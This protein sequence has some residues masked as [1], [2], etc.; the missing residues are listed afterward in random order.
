MDE[1]L[2]QICMLLFKH[3]DLLYLD[4][5]MVDDGCPPVIVW[6][7]FFTEILNHGLMNEVSLK[8]HTLLGS[9]TLDIYATNTSEKPV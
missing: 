1:V 4:T 5:I 6:Q 3:G 2:G 9:I 7:F 8:D